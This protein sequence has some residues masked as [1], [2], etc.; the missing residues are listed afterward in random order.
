MK[1]FLQIII[2]FHTDHR[3]YPSYRD[4]C[5]I[6]DFSSTFAVRRYLDALIKKGYMARN[7]GL[8]RTYW[9]LKY[10]NDE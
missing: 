8:A 7:P 6:L 9:I 5:E 1:H 3:Y 4:L 2:D 10:P